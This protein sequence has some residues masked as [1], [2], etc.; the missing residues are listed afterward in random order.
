MRGR[1]PALFCLE[2]DSKPEIDS[3]PETEPSTHVGPKPMTK[4]LGELAELAFQLKAER[5]GFRVSK[6]YGDSDPYDFHADSGRAIWRV[7]IKSTASC[8]CGGFTLHVGKNQRRELRSYL[9]SEIDFIVGYVIPRDVWYVVPV[10][11]LGKAKYLRLHPDRYRC[12]RHGAWE[13]YREAWCLMACRRDG[14][15]EDLDI[16]RR[17]DESVVCPFER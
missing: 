13:K 1:R 16:A 17:C 15:F 4:K 3:V 5:L 9:P 2:Q 10:S 14:R 12:R 6:P 8:N 11:A 7:Q